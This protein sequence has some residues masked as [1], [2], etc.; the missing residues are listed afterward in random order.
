MNE[1]TKNLPDF[2]K[3][4]FW[5]YDFLELTLTS[6]SDLITSRLLQAGDW[7]SICW[8]REQ[9][10]DD[11]LR[12]WLLEHQGGGLSPRQLRYWQVILELPSDMVNVWVRTAR[13]NPWGRRI[14]K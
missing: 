6:D 2:L 13:D 1:K 3:R 8:L 9:M 10:E 12:R 11:D 5:D 4:F 14:R 7:R